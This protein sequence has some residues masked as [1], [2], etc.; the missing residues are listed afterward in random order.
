MTVQL[1]HSQLSRAKCSECST[2]YKVN[3]D[4]SLRQHK[5]TPYWISHSSTTLDDNT[6]LEQSPTTL[7]SATDHTVT[8]YG[9]P[10]CQ[11]KKRKKTRVSLRPWTKM[12][13]R[14]R[15]VPYYA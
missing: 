2:A 5:C 7:A 1:N 8:S 3:K 11:E 13:D 12:L 14:R 4:G 6:V 15:S 9:K 10:A